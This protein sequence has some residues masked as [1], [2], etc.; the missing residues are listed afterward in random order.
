MC[1]DLAAAIDAEHVTLLLFESPERAVS[2]VAHNARSSAD[3]GY[4]L[5]QAR[6]QELWQSAGIG[7]W[8]EEH[9][10]RPTRGADGE[11]LAAAGWRNA[12]C[13]PV[14]SGDELIGVLSAGN[15]IERSSEELARSLP[16]VAEYARVAGA[17]LGRTLAG[18]RQAADV[19]RSIETIIAD[20]AFAPVFQP[21][22]ELAST[23]L[24][25]YEALSRFADGV[26]PD[27]RFADAGAVGLGRE[28]EFATIEAALRAS[29]SLPKNRW[30]SL[31]VSP[32]VALSGARLKRLLE[33]AGRPL[34]IELTEHAPVADYPALR[35]AIA[36]LGG[37]IRV[38]V[39]DAGAGYASMQHVVELRPDLIKLDI[40]L[41][42]GIDRDTARQAL[43]AGM[44]YF[45]E[46]TNCLLLGE[47]VE[48]EA[49]LATL[50]RL[51]VAL[52]QGY[53]LG[54]PAAADNLAAVSTS[55]RV[56]AATR[57]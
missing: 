44:R 27:E 37:G 26:R 56:T 40:S 20:R 17:L 31:N 34:V 33:I 54:R 39:D 4:A 25:G 50:G 23:R 57:G 32:E 22:V 36:A 21:I 10:A 52:G 49:E 53:L 29:R 1:A 48:T 2:F 45:A 51:G 38:A 41:V 8:V 35:R 28:L 12:V 46:Q 9:V 18:R 6:S 7:P 24:V 3:I 47:G 15:S 30:L 5:P 14:R 16:S 43:V 42:R 13:A 19:R 11:R 55:K